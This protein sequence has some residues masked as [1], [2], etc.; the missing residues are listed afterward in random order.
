VLQQWASAEPV[1]IEEVERT[2]MVMVYSNQ[3]AGLAQCN[4][5]TMDVDWRNRNCYSCGGFGHLARNCKNRG[6]ENRIEEGRRLEYEQNNRQRLMVEG[7]NRQSNLNRERDL[8]V[9]N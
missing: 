6:I 8:V 2:N 1:L 7:N 4:S 9:L 5:Y 3:R